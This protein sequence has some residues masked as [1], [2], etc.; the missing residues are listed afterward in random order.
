MRTT[1]HRLTLAPARSALA[2]ALLAGLLLTMLALAP[3]RAGAQSGAQTQ[4]ES[5]AAVD[6]VSCP[7]VGACVAV[8][9]YQATGGVPLGL[10]LT[11]TR[12]RFAAAQAKLPGGAS[13][14][15]NVN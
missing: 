11:Q 8:G 10:L 13:G 3:A 12:G 5:D 1:P 9:S 7:A 2:A 6:S 15:P 14:T 4:L